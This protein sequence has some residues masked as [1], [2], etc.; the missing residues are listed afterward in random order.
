VHALKSDV[1]EKVP[2]MQGMHL[3]PSLF[4]PKPGGQVP[5]KVALGEGGSSAGQDVQEEEPVCDE[6]EG[7]ERG[8]GENQRARSEERGAKRRVK[9]Y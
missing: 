9:D 6:R 3:V 4:V 2:G 1:K 8:K 5:Q 7:H